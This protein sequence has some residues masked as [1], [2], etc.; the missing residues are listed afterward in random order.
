MIKEKEKHFNIK[1]V[2]NYFEVKEEDKHSNV[3][4]GVKLEI[5]DVG[6]HHI[7]IEEISFNGKDRNNTG[8]KKI[9]KK[10]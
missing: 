7:D 4:D 10:K 9:N 8:E 1:D 3:E 6:K 2:E 5:E